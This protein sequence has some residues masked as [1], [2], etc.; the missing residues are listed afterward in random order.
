MQ[1]TIKH[2]NICILGAQEGE[3]RERK[4]QKEYLKKESP[5]ISRN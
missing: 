1:D 4:G 2:I 3:E 5:N